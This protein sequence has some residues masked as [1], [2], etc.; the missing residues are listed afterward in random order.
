MNSCHQTCAKFFSFLWRD[1][2]SDI[3]PEPT[4]SEHRRAQRKASPI[5]DRSEAEK[6]VALAGASTSVLLL[7]QATEEANCS[8]YGASSLITCNEEVGILK[9]LLLEKEI[10][11]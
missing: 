10:F 4:R 2:K 8:I 9:L 1:G 6:G 7:C 11:S 3:P 5:G